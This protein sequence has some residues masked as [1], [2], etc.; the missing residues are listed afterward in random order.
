MRVR[1]ALLALGGSLALT[2]CAGSAAH[3]TPAGA[4][5][6]A[7]RWPDATV[8]SLERDRD[9]YIDK[10]SGCHLL[11]GTNK[12]A[13]RDWPKTVSIMSKKGKFDDQTRESI[14]RYLTAVTTPSD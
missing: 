7:R 3:P 13:I 5:A 1:L 9:T 14:L 2:S 8:A 6:A 12:M 4:A 10:C 11:V